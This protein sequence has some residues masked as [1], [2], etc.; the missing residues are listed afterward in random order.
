MSL[1]EH[2]HRSRRTQLR[3]VK[4]R[5]ASSYRFSHLEPALRLAAEDPEVGCSSPQR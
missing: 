4:L 2:L 3:P 1:P 5:S